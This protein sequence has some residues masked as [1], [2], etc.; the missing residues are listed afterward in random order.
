MLF[1]QIARVG[2]R[3]VEKGMVIPLEKEVSRRFLSYES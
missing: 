1:R 3:Y 2:W